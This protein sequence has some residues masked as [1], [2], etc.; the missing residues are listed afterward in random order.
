ME[1][2]IVFTGGGTGGHIYPGI[3]TAKAL[4]SRIEN[5]SVLFMGTKRGL[6][7][8]L[9]PQE[10]FEISFISAM[11]LSSHPV[12]ALFAMLSV[13]LGL[14]QSLR[15]MMTFKP[16]LVVGTGGYVSGP[17]ALAASLAGVPV[18]IFEQNIIPGKTTRFLSRLARKVCVS[19]RETGRY[20]PSEKVVV[21]G[22][23]VREAILTRSRE[24]GRA[25]LSIA[26]GRRCILVTGA[27]QGAR[28]INDG[29]LNALASWRD[30]EWTIIHLTGEKNFEQ[31]KNR[32]EALV[33]GAKLDY[34]CLGFLRNMEEAYAASDLAVCRAGA[35]TLAEITARGIPAILIPYPYS[36]EAHQ[37]KN[38]AWLQDNGAGVM[39]QDAEVNEKLSAT[40][41]RLL[42]DE[43]SL[44]AMAA[45]CRALGKPDALNDIV[46]VILE[47]IGD[48][49]AY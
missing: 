43:A 31:V 32:A 10:G 44:G 8:Q 45:N 47:I 6:E 9:V 48:R 40:V 24:E 36:A 27:S 39:I 25:A 30:K 11:G 37:E 29:I 18:V 13:S 20:L 5:L 41:T 14:L 3:A 4:K 1:R 49:L 21:T 16:H 22:N 33:Q 23:P 35:T 38:A 19:F 34:R 42:D 17:V 12:K 15:L 2:R 26:P 7:A 46:N 28:S